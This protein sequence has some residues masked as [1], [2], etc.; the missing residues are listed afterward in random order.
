MRGR[1]GGSKLTTVIVLSVL[2]VVVGTGVGLYNYYNDLRNDSINH[3]TRLAAQYM[4][5]QNYL[6]NYI[7]GF[8]EQVDVANL[9]SEQLDNILR[10]AVKG[11][12]EDSGGFSTGGSFFS[13]LREDYPDLA[14]LDIYDEVVNYVSAHREGYRAKQT[15]LLDMLRAYDRWRQRGVVQHWIIDNWVGVP[16]ERLEARIGG[17]VVATGEDAREQM[18]Q[19]VLTSE[20]NEAYE[21][22]EMGP[23][24]APRPQN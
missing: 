22:G 16:T 5:N 14:G 23:L 6:S 1:R 24:E 15:K 19:I 9:K 7:N 17:E 4:D 2:A 10:G 20:S 11:R 21:D 12:Y 13:I 8:Y 18:Y 3:E